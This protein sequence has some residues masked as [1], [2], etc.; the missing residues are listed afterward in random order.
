MQYSPAQ[1][2]AIVILMIILVIAIVYIGVLFADMKK[3][4]KDNLALQRL[5]K[6]ERELVSEQ[7]TELSAAKRVYPGRVY[8][9]LQGERYLVSH[10]NGDRIGLRDYNT[11]SLH[12][13][14]HANFLAYYTLTDLSRVSA[15]ER[16][17]ISAARIREEI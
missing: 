17:Q 2:W 10:V 5:L 1:S 9:N 6:G 8:E 13:I 3:V 16:T 11:Y 7:R 4:L 15:Y 12:E 14:T